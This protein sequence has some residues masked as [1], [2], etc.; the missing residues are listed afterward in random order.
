MKVRI[1]YSIDLA[2]VPAKSA[3]MLSPIST[4]LSRLESKLF[5]LVGELQSDDPDLGLIVKGID[6]A[7]L[8]LGDCDGI[9][10]EVGTIISG[11]KEHA[12]QATEAEET[13]TEIEQ[14]A[15]S[16]LNEVKKTTEVMTGRTLREVPDEPD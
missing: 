16:T 9:L 12:E 6:R 14:K 1:S 2:E 5:N 13:I 15:E 8:V 7:R 10:T 11:L 4:K 3:E